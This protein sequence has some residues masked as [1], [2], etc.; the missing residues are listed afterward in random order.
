V[1]GGGISRPGVREFDLVCVREDVYGAVLN[2]L[3][4][5]DR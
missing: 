3:C 5:L 4:P 2:V 1:G